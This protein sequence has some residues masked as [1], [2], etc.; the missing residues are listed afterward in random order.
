MS[1][2]LSRRGESESLTPESKVVPVGKS[3]FVL[4]VVFPLAQ[5]KVIGASFAQTELVASWSPLVL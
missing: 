2:S 3:F 5:A 1:S 4:V